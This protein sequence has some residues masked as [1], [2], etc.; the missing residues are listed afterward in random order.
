MSLD[1]QQEDGIE[2]REEG[3]SD[4]DSL[5]PADQG[6]G[7]WKFLFASWVLDALLWGNLGDQRVSNGMLT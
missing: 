1:R 5:C 3:R 6:I 7:A 2:F 4:F